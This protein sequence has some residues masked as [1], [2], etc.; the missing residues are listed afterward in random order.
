MIE[1]IDIE[2]FRCFPV[3]RV[4]TLSRIN[5]IVG[6]NSSGKTAFLESIFLSSAATAPQVAF[7]MRA[8]RHLGN[9]VQII[10]EAGAYMGLWRDLFHWYRDEIP[11]QITVNGNSG[12]SR[13]LKISYSGPIDQLLPFG[14]QVV[15]TPVF[16]QIVFEWKRGDN[17]PIEIKPRLT[18]AG[19]SFEGM[20]IDHFPVIFFS[21]Q[22]L[23]APEETAKRF[24]ELSKAGEVQPIVDI[25][26]KE[27]P[28]IDNLTIEY[29]SSVGTLFASIVG[30]KEKL[31]LGLVSD[32]VHK[33]V[34]YLLGIQ[35]F[36]GGAILIDQIEDG[37]Y[38]E[39]L[40]SIWKIL[41][42]FAVD[43]NVQIFATT[44]SQ[45]CLTAM[46]PTIVKN[47]DNFVLLK[48]ERENDSC[49]VT[50]VKSKFFEAALEQDFE[51][52]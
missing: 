2:N 48:A 32:G 28:F 51:I 14:Q 10:G 35:S 33:L 42:D 29:N 27:F 31:P 7:Q 40:A 5:M 45:E 11:V 47:R 15:S 30:H 3:L 25:L 6:R 46:L 12:D 52:R 38:Y 18:G 36:R 23:D 20:V 37:F 24:S 34:A 41:H 9:Q 19:L 17:P 49:S 22:A 16:P 4:T 13:S 43:N 21:P 39:R 44:H 26:K 50:Q 8:L 1:S